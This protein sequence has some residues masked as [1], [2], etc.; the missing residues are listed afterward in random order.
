MDSYEFIVGI[1]SET[2]EDGC[3]QDEDEEYLLNYVIQPNGTGY[4]VVQTYEYERSS[5][6]CEPTVVV[7]EDTGTYTLHTSPNNIDLYNVTTD[8]NTYGGGAGGDAYSYTE[9]VRDTVHFYRCP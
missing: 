2:S 5:S 6:G 7:D 9:V 1:E 8:Y 4:R 3:A